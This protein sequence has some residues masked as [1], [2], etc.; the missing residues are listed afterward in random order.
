MY[1]EKDLE[2]R[3]GGEILGTRQSGFTN[4]NGKDFFITH[5]EED[6][7][8]SSILSKV[9]VHKYRSANKFY[10]KYQFAQPKTSPFYY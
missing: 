3:G 1:T 10:N 6:C 2:L 5:S 4:F 9:K 7:D 8:N